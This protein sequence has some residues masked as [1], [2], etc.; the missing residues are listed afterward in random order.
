MTDKDIGLNRYKDI[1]ERILERLDSLIGEMKLQTALMRQMN[2]K[3]Q[4]IYPEIRKDMIIHELLKG[5][6]LRTRDVMNI[7]NV[8]KPTAIQYMV[9]IST[10]K[11]YILKDYK[12]KRGLILAKKVNH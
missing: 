3:E 7:L 12:G 6:L 2:N 10:D 1:N 9:S 11:K 5:R 8:S 4:I